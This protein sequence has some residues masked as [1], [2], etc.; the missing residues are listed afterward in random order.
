MNT[1]EKIKTILAARE[2]G[3]I[4]PPSYRGR[5]K[6]RDVAFPF[7]MGAGSVGTVT[8]T[9]PASIFAFLNDTTDPLTAFGQACL[10]NGANNDVR[11]ILTSDDE[12]TAI[13]G[14]SVRPYPFAGTPTATVG[15]PSPFGG[16]GPASGLQVDI[17]RSGSILVPVSGLTEGGTPNLGAP[18][19]IWV[20]A[21]AGDHVLGGF[22]TETSGSTITLDAKTAWGG[23]ADANGIAELFFNI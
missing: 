18:V 7:R 8:R 5:H 17:L 10:F 20:A 21:S 23:P 4:L 3:L 12:I 22:E 19:Y 16:E 6:V 14:V 13:A 1:I 9:H 15:S 2:S 11:S